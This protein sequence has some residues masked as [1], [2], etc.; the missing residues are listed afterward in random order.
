MGNH[1][2]DSIAPRMVALE[3]E[4]LLLRYHNLRLLEHLQRW[5]P[6]QGVDAVIYLEMKSQGTE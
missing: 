4:N 2:G 3:K 5:H 6:P 1:D